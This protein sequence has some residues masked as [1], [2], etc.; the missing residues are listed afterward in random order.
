MLFF[1]RRKN[2]EIKSKFGTKNFFTIVIYITVQYASVFDVV[3]YTK[4]SC[5]T[6]ASKL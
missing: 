6:V 2:L 1:W 4:L 5:F 3:E